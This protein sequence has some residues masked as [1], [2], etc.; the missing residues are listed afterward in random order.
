MSTVI[1]K[2]G[3]YVA[4]KVREKP[5]S[6][7]KLLTAAYRGKKAQLRYFP[8]KKLSP[9][10]NYMA[11]QSMNAILA[12]LLH[13]QQAALVSIFMPCE[14]LQVFGMAP[15]F[16]EAM[17][18]YISGAAA[19]RGFVE[20]TESCGIAETYCSYHKVLLGGIL[21]GVIP[22]P[23]LVVNTSLVCDANNLTFR[24]AAEHYGI[25]HFFVDV[26]CERTQE[27]VEYVAGQLQDLALFLVDITGKRLDMD[28]LQAAVGRSCRTVERFRECQRAKR[29]KYLH[30]DITSEL[31]EVFGTHVLLGTPEMEKYADILLRDIQASAPARGVRLLWMHT[32][33]YYQEAL[34]ELL[35]FSDRCQVVSCDMNFDAFCDMNPERPFES[36][37]RRLVLNSFN[38][39]FEHRIRRSIRMCRE[40]EIDGVV[41]FCHWGCKQTL[42]AAGNAREMLEEAGIPALIL[43]GD[44]CDRNNSG[45]GQMAT[46]IQAFIE[47][48]EGK[49]R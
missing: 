1:E 46:R 33:P 49:K 32:I 47:M 18:C 9:A 25:P 10:R 14:L 22:R 24:S 38:G 28:E 41:Y 36:M 15:M 39:S 45:N 23:K 11:L 17:A 48:L 4:D 8:D 43:D 20:Y 5:G 37:A 42:G 19:E 31:Y 12:P 3:N 30:N 16:A 21:S 2:F 40:Q 26:P 6:A 29:G 44:G 13:P 34:R 35:N 27:S 7:R